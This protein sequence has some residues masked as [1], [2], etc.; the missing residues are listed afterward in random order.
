MAVFYKDQAG[1]VLAA[2]SSDMPAPAGFEEARGRNGRCCS[3]KA[4]SRCFA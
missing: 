4:R 1:N 2:L 3:R